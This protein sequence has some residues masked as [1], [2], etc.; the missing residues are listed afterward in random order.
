MAGETAASLAADAEALTALQ[1]ALTARAE[2]VDGLQQGAVDDIAA[3]SDYWGGPRAIDVLGAADAYV[4]AVAPAAG[5]IESA[6]GT[7]GTWA[8]DA[9][10]ASEAMAV[11]ERALS[12]ANYA[13]RSGL[14]TPTEHQDAVDDAAAA[15]SQIDVIRG[16]W[17]TTCSTHAATLADAISA[18][19][20]S[21]TTVIA[22]DDQTAMYDNSYYAKIA[23]L[24]VLAGLSP[25]LVD[26]TGQLEQAILDRSAL[27]GSEDGAL[28]F[29]I[30]ET[31]NEGDL[32]KADGNFSMDDIIAAC[33]PA[34]VEAL[35]RQA[36]E[37]SGH[38]WD[39]AEFDFL[40]SEIVGTAWMMRASEDEVWEDID[41]D[42]E[43]YERGVVNWAK[44]NLLAPVASITV[45]ALCYSAAVGGSTVTGGASLA[46]AAY[47]GGLAA[48][49]YN[50]TNTWAHGGSAGDV[51]DSF[52]DLETWAYGATEGLVFQGATNYLLRNP[53]VRSTA[54]GAAGS[55]DEVAQAVDDLPTSPATP[56]GN[57]YS[58]A[59]ETELDPADWG[60][61]RA[62]H[63]NR[64]N[65]SLDTA[66]TADESF[67]AALDDVIP[68]V[69]ESV[70]SVGGRSTPD[71]WTWHH[72]P[73]S[74]A[75]GR[76]GVMQLVPTEQH[77]PGSIFQGA[78]HP[79]GQG[80]YS[81]WAVPAGAP[82][83]R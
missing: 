66:L 28:L 19:F 7:V 70:S 58:V 12:S 62:V 57:Q 69:H 46:G 67:A 45:G 79:N 71:G 60:R 68:G 17:Q 29:L 56:S 81:E 50:A 15:S 80:G 43:W 63:D 21:S 74:A 64:A 47:C 72:V 18:L 65:A 2:L 76:M 77:A 75:D 20:T 40:V 11:Q 83:N 33:D 53:A 31:A 4:E 5:A 54:G 22:A 26:P 13:L 30:M 3:I 48:A 32:G 39:E 10:A 51:V 61:R 73:S 37:E 55:A 35:L 36:A 27:L 23:E 25:D 42:I 78:F 16:A 24:T 59:W 82:P 1:D 41:D 34:T 49:T 6:A 14:E 38:E 8:A 52:T 9:L 44:E